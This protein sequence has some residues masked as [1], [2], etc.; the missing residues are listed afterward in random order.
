MTKSQE[1]KKE[2][3]WTK[4][5]ILLLLSNFLTMVGFQVLMPT[6]P[7]FVSAQAG[8]SSD[9]GLV[10]GILTIA[11][12]IIRPFSG[13]AADTVGRKIVLTTGVF[14][15]FSAMILY[16]RAFTVSTIILVRIVHGIGWGIATAAF[17]TLASDMV[18]AARRGEGIGYFGFSALIAGALGPLMGIEL[19]HSFR[20]Q[21]VLVFSAASTF[22][23]LIVLW[24]IKVPTLETTQEE[25]H[26]RSITAKLV[27][28]T[29]LFPSLLIGFVGLV[30]GG[31]VTF[32]TLF[33]AEAGIANVGWFFLINAVSSFLIRP[34][35]GRL[36]DQK[37]HI[38]VLLPGALFALTGI[39]CLSF[40]TS[41]WL[42]S[43]AAVFFGL[44]VGAIQP[45]LQAWVINRAAPNR[46]G[47]ANSTFFSAFDLGISG[48]AMMLGGVAKAFNYAIMYRFSSLFLILFVLVYLI[49]ILKYN[50][51]VRTQA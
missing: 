22:I 42:L 9:V 24:L 33:G 46:R 23:S 41:T 37:G 4:A 16:F 28:K 11:A 43:V 50:T 45:A 3:L 13:A 34:I 18:P 47:A 19:M 31:I 48:G 39:L 17:G 27:E 12:V 5:F 25:P 8:N 36:F 40:A 30:Y 14:I 35:S 38:Y 20:F 21:A 51:K 7:M 32:I 10:I 15:C 6:L 1:L 29:S 49:Y 44:G 2:A 26:S